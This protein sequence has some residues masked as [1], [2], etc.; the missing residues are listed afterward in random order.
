[1][2]IVIRFLLSVI[3]E[4]TYDLYRYGESFFNNLGSLEGF[5]APHFH[6]VS[7]KRRGTYS[8]FPRCEERDT[9]KEE[10][11]GACRVQRAKLAN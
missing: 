8:F 7:S 11:V 2:Y 5:F 3:A 4:H 1:M 6:Y 10:E 9:E